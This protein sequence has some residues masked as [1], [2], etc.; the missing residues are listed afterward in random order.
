M[1]TWFLALPWWEAMRALGLLSFAAIT[2]GICLGILYSLPFWSAPVK[3]RLYKT[4]AALAIDG[5]ALGLGHGMLTVIDTYVPYSWSEL[6]IPFT[7]S[8][9]PVLSGLGTLSFYALVLIILSTDLRGKL[10]RPLWFALHLSAYPAFVM[11][12]VHGFFMGT[13]SGSLAAQW[14]YALSACSV[15]LATLVRAAYRSFANT[16]KG[17]RGRPAALRRKGSVS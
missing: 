14:F 8:Y 17:G 5:A 16:G 3:K 9:R 2:A 4:H 1:M 15:V 12:L 13:D 11:A 7:A 6:L 10:K